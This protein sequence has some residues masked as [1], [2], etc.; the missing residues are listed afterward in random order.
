MWV[1]LP[2]IRSSTSPT[3]D[4]NGYKLQD[5]VKKE[6]HLARLPIDSS[7]VQVPGMKNMNTGIKNL[8][9]ELPMRKN[10][11]R[12]LGPAWTILYTKI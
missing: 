11:V 10:F 1:T 9:G 4:E 3:Y 2:T 12:G 5:H 6:K 8:Y 7:L